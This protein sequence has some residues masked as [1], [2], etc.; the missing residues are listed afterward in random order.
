VIVLAE[1]QLA[2]SDPALPRL[3]RLGEPLLEEANR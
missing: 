3:V 2:A 1:A